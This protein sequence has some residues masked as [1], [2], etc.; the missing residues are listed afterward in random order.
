MRGFGL[1]FFW[2][3]KER[4]EGGMLDY[5]VMGERVCLF[6]SSLL[7]DFIWFDLV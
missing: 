4:G 2:G 1:L 6:F 3:E 7:I 5:L